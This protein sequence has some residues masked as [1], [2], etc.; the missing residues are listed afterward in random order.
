MNIYEQWGFRA[1]PFDTR[2]L[3]PDSQGEELLIGRDKELAALERRLYTP[4]NI[5][6]IEGMHGIGKTSLVNILLYRCKKRQLMVEQSYGYVFVPCAESFRL[7]PESHIEIFEDQLYIALAQTI[8]DNAAFLR[9]RCRSELPHLETVNKHLNATDISNYTSAIEGIGDECNQS[10][11]PVPPNFLRAGLRTHV[12]RWLKEMFSEP[13]RGGVI[14]VLDNVEL[15]KTVPDARKFIEKLRD[16]VFQTTGLRWVMCGSW[17]IILGVIASSRLEGILDRPITLSRVPTESAALI[18]ESRIKTYAKKVDDVVLPFTRDDYIILYDIMKGN[19]R[20][21]LSGLGDYCKWYCDEYFAE[22]EKDDLKGKP[23][24]EKHYAFLRW[25]QDRTEDE[26]YKMKKKLRPEA[27]SIFEAASTQNGEFSRYDIER[28]S[29]GDDKKKKKVSLLEGLEELTDHFLLAHDP[30]ERESQRRFYHMTTRGWLVNHAVRRERKKQKGEISG[31]THHQTQRESSEPAG[32]AELYEDFASDYKV[33][34]LAS[35]DK[36]FNLDSDNMVFISYAMTDRA[37]A[38]YLASRLRHCGVKP[39]IDSEAIL[40]GENRRL[41][42]REAIR[43]SLAF[44]VLLSS[45]SVGERGSLHT[46]I[47]MALKI[48]SEMP[49]GRIYLIPARI[50]DCKIRHEKLNEIQHVDLFPDRD[51]GIRKI[52]ESLKKVGANIEFRDT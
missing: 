7:R 37:E 27:W 24:S 22:A 46:E 43:K 41:A 34:N 12:K 23:N 40:P 31:F 17:G 2:A 51:L 16:G 6:S 50:E 52:I 15:L 26:Y 20:Y 11:F 25:L 39:W 49:S 30:A 42:R 44:I 38:E 45:R 36:T 10:Q 29:K 4:P 9:S 8:I 3:S 48:L 33:F 13:K 18:L 35:D 5:P 32:A 14:C 21:T 1:D 47:E 28:M 19:I